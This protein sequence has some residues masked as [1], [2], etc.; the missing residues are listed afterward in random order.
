MFA[1][2]PPRDQ[3]QKLSFR[4]LLIGESVLPSFVLLGVPSGSIIVLRWF[5]FQQ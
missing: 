4:D 5:Q 2:S 3:K 1:V